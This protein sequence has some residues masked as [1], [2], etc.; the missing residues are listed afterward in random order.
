[1]SSVSSMSSMSS[2][3]SRSSMSLS[4]SSSTVQRVPQDLARALQA[5]PRGPALGTECRASARHWRDLGR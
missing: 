3:S 5:G 1:M 4:S 2:M